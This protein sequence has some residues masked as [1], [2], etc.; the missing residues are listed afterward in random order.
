MD[1]KQI[2]RKKE[3]ELIELVSNFCRRKLN[4]NINNFVLSWFKKL[5]RKRN[6]PFLTG[7]ME[8]WA[9]LSYIRL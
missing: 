1:T 4:R 7:K 8:I 2:K 9:A 6:V 3:E 5:G